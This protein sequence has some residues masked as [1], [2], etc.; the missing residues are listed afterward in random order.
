MG[1]KNVVG[2]AAEYGI[3][4]FLWDDGGDVQILERD[5]LKWNCKEYIDSVI[6]N[7]KLMTKK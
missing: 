6:E 3:P 7:S 1:G 5:K 2:G 4:V